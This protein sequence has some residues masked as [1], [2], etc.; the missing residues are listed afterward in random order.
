MDYADAVLTD[1]VPP[2]EII[3]CEPTSEQISQINNSLSKQNFPQDK[4]DLARLLVKDYC[5]SVGHIKGLMNQFT[6]SS[7]KLE[8]AKITYNNC[9]DPQNYYQ[10]IDLLTFPSEKDEL[11]YW[12]WKQ[13][14]I[15]YLCS[16]FLYS[17]YPLNEETLTF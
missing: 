4:L 5:F 6:F 17:S 14:G 1:M 8:L 12:I 11:R 2:S 7:D 10:L 3:I 16:I 13:T 15:K 9:P